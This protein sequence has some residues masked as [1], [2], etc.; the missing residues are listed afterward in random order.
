MHKLDLAREAFSRF[1][2]L[3]LKLSSHEDL[4]KSVKS[5]LTQMLTKPHL[6]SKL[7]QLKLSM[8]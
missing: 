2:E 5:E 1:D 7:D 8:D 6:H 4:L 3:D